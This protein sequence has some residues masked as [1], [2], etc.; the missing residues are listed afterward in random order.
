MELEKCIALLRCGDE[1]GTAFFIARDVAISAKHVCID[2]IDDPAVPVILHLGDLSIS[3]HVIDVEIPD[4]EDT[5][6]LRTETKV[7]ASFVLS[8]DAKYI[9]RNAAWTSFGYPRVRA[10]HGAELRGTVARRL[11][12]SIAAWDL[13]L[14][15]TQW[16]DFSDYEGFSGS[17]VLVDGS[18]RAMVQRQL[19]GALGAISFLRLRGVLRSVGV[20]YQSAENRRRIPRKLLAD[21][22]DTIANLRTS[23]D[24]DEV[25]SDLSSGYVV[26]FGPPGSGKTL[27]A[28]GYAPGDNQQTVVGRYFIGI[29]ND[30]IAL[31]ALHYR[32]ASVF[33]TWLAEEVAFVSD[34]ASLPGP[35][36]STSEVTRSIATNLQLISSL[37]GAP[38]RVLIIDSVESIATPSGFSDFIQLLPER[39][40]AG[41]IVVITTTNGAAFATTHSHL[42]LD[43]MLEMAPLPILDCEKLILVKVGEDISRSD[44]VDLARASQGNPLVL[45]LLISEYL[46][47]V[48]LQQKPNIAQLINGL[49]GNPQSYYTRAWQRLLDDPHA[50]WIMATIARIRGRVSASELVLM[51]PRETT[52]FFSTSF[53]RLRHLLRDDAHGVE[54]YHDSFRQFV[55][56]QTATIDKAVHD[57]IAAYSLQAD[58][59]R[60]AISSRVFHHLRGSETTRRK[61]SE[62]CTQE[63]F[64]KAA[65]LYLAPDTLLNDLDELLAA[66]LSSGDLVS[67]LRFLLLRSR[68]R[69]RNNSLWAIHSSD[70]AKLALRAYGGDAALSFVVRQG[71]IICS[72]EDVV[73]LLRQMVVRREF[74]AARILAD[75]FRAQCYIAYETGG[76]GFELLGVHIE[77]AALTLDGPSSAAETRSL[78]RLAEKN[79]ERRDSE[80]EKDR[81]LM[82][83]LKADMFGQLLWLVGF[84]PR[85]QQADITNDPTLW[86]MELALTLSRAEELAATEDMPVAYP[87]R[88]DEMAGHKFLTRSEAV[89]ELAQVVLAHG[90]LPVLA[91]MVVDTLIKNHASADAVRALPEIDSPGLISLREANGVDAN[92]TKISRLRYSARRKAYLSAT[93]ERDF[94]LDTRHGWESRFI[95]STWWLGATYGV[96]SRAVHDQRKVSGSLLNNIES[97]LLP[98]LLFS[99]EERASWE[100]AYQL[101]ESITPQLFSWTMELL[102][103]FEP[104]SVPKFIAMLFEKG[105][106]Q[107]GLYSE[108]F[109][110]TL[111][112][113]ARAAARYGNK[114]ES[115]HICGLLEVHFLKSVFSRRERVRGFIECAK[116]FQVLGDTIRAESA[117]LHAIESSLGP[118]WYKEDQLSLFG[119]ALRAIDDPTVTAE[120]WKQGTEIL[121]LAAG[122]ATFQRFVRHE[123]E[124]LIGLLA[125]HG[126]I[127]QAIG[128]YQHFVSPTASVQIERILQCPVDRFRRLFGSRFGVLEVDQQSGAEQ[129]LDGL[130]AAAPT[131]RWAIVE[132]FTPG[133]DRYLQD[134]A[135]HAVGA[136]AEDTGG[137]VS[138]RALR[139]IQAEIPKSMRSGFLHSISQHERA[140][141]IESWLTAI[142]DLGLAT[143]EQADDGIP[144]EIREALS[145]RRN[146]RSQASK[147]DTDDSLFPGTIGRPS[148]LE[149]LEKILS[150]IER[151]SALGDIPGI[152]RGLVDGLEAA[153]AGEWSIWRGLETAQKG[154]AVLFSHGAVSEVVRQL[155]PMVERERHTLDWEIAGCLMKNA[156]P[157]A[158]VAVRT[159]VLDLVLD[160]LYRILN[161]EKRYLALGTK[162]F[163]PILPPERQSTD[164]YI[165]D[166]LVWVLDHPDGFVRNRA[167]DLLYWMKNENSDV[168]LL[169]ERALGAQVGYGSELCAGILHALAIREPQRVWRAVSTKIPMRGALSL[170]VKTALEAIAKLARHQGD[171]V[172]ND[173]VEAA[174]R[175]R[176][177]NQPS[178]VAWSR[179]VDRIRRRSVE[180]KSATDAEFA[181]LSGDHELSSL[182]VSEAWQIRELAFQTT[183][184]GEWGSPW[185]RAALFNAIERLTPSDGPATVE[186]ISL[187]NPFWPDS[188]LHVDWEPRGE[189]IL[190]A[191]EEGSADGCFDVGSETILHAVDVLRDADGHKTIEVI[192]FFVNK[193]FFNGSIDEDHLTQ[194]G[195]LFGRE[196]NRPLSLL[197]PIN[198][199][200]V[201]QFAPQPAAGGDLTPAVTTPLFQSLT[202]TE[203][204][205]V[206]RIAWRKSRACRAS[207]AGPPL[208]Q[209]SVL[210]VQSAGIRRLLDRDLVW[211]VYENEQLRFIVDRVRR[212]IYRAER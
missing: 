46:S 133:D 126:H 105:E 9:P 86:G 144:P 22:K 188:D 111:R 165:E 203:G 113:L 130:S 104:Q 114:D 62:L 12:T 3:A 193:A 185:E 55:L 207:A 194:I 131:H 179:A 79:I 44:A 134:F 30:E 21:L 37:P 201:I 195:S 129:L 209:G 47:G 16:S 137:R 152:Q 71:H 95:E 61:A 67:T 26:V 167:A 202:R 60:Y 191:I 82:A 140:S 19:D 212:S 196:S 52:T 42:H 151:L 122:E 150:Q 206:R 127:R 40:P 147:G 70:L 92:W 13:E 43:A 15:C 35:A 27:F 23:W 80:E 53:V 109:A 171:I 117:F 76:A 11:R 178:T 65:S 123:K 141:E 172:A 75:T 145:K 200:A 36:A 175:P 48:E 25:T 197:A 186:S 83:K 180:L 107:L 58:T 163:E 136:L 96:R 100:D 155:K 10:K 85:Q 183:N 1:Q 4:S 51:L 32:D 8:I 187:Y 73:A 112:G 68:I 24:L 89:E 102:G 161:P 49:A 2:H 108:G 17:P 157:R 170:P 135:G 57:A 115:L 211:V 5:I 31:P 164:L 181:R 50:V 93:I 192:A 66:S 45:R 120:R 87:D 38:K 154:F 77:V 124:G 168:V 204:T 132:L 54:I 98:S 139:F 59:S 158:D 173:I 174:E 156:L 63:W 182:L 14:R 29:A 143:E 198:E 72:P 162:T 153:Q 106:V 84:F 101:P 208:A 6:L 33:A 94:T 199:A 28:A 205:A 169:V 148:A 41:L 128:L 39:L 78:L 177:E 103:E 176:A 97:E 7:D 159:A 69:F 81:F 142:K 88:P 166:F 90:I 149:K 146:A 184:V 189:A 121:E 116:M 210:L 118:D 74:E 119:S 190:R 138:E 99:L 110:S 91:P 64:D 18:V 56:H 34:S 125:V 20:E 160:H